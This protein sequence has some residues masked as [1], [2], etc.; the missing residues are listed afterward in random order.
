[1]ADIDGADQRTGFGRYLASVAERD[2]DLLLM[3]EFH[4]SDDFVAW[5]CG[6]AGLANVAPAGAWHSVSDTDGESDLLLRV[7]SD[8]KR[9]GILIE[10]KIA[11]PEQDLQAERYHLRGIRSREQGKIDD[12]VT[13]MCAPKRYLDGLGETSAYQHRIAYER[14]ADWYAGQQGRRAAWRHHILREAIEQGRRGYTMAVN[15]TNTAF[16]LAYWEH[17]RKRHPKIQMARPKSRGSKST[18]II[19]KGLDFPKNVN[20]HHKFDQQVME[21]G[22]AGRT[23]DELLAAN[24]DWPDDIVP[25]QKGGTAS[26]AIR[27]PLID[28]KLRIA[29]Q[30]PAVERALAAAYRLMPYANL[31]KTRAAAPPEKL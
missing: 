18:W 8:G 13:V 11:A 27:V 24:A 1:M 23:V 2:I 5:F 4:I 26:L 28:M 16:H 15:A 22:F 17:L 10:N 30:L 6:R 14:I 25:V 3:E 29:E 12:Y 19:L 21:I 9:V 7:T 20:M 31:L